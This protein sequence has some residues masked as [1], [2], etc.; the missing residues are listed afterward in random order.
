MAAEQD[1]TSSP[2][3]KAILSDEIIARLRCRPELPSSPPVRNLALNDTTTTSER[4]TEPPP[5]IADHTLLRL[6]GRG[7][8]GEVWLAVNV[9]GAYRAV[10]IVYQNRFEDSRPFDREFN[11]LLRYEPIS[12]SH[13][14]QVDILHVG[15][16]EVSGYFYYIMELADDQ[17]L[18][19]HLDPARYR[20]RTLRSDV[21]K[22]RRLPF[23]ECL[24]IGLALATAL[25]HLH[26][27]G[28]VHRD[29]KPSNIVFINGIPKLAD[30]GLIACAEETR[31]FVGTE[32]F[33]PPEGPGLPQADLYALG[34]VIYEMS[35]GRDRKEFPQL[36][37][38]LRESPDQGRLLELNEII[39]KACHPDPHQR[40]Q[41]AEEMHADLAMLQ[42]GKSVIGARNLERRLLLARRFGRVLIFVVLAALAGSYHILR[43]KQKIAQQLIRFQLAQGIQLMEEDRY[44]E[45]LPWF[46]ESLALG[47]KNAELHRLRLS[48]ILNQ[49]PRLI[50]LLPHR[51]L[52]NDIELSPD[53]QSIAT[54]SDDGSARVWNLISGTPRTPRLQHQMEVRSV[55]F[56][57]D[58]CHVITASSDG[59]ARVW[60]LSSGGN[61][62]PPLIHDQPV[63]EASFS[64]DGKLVLTACLD[65]SARIWDAVSGKLVG[66]PLSHALP[67]WRARF[68]PDGRHILTLARQTEAAQVEG[69]A[70][71]WHS[72]GDS[73][74]LVS[75]LQ[76]PKASDAVFSPDGQWVAT[77]GDDLCVRIWSTV[78]GRLQGTP[79]VHS[80]AVNYAEFSQNSRRLVAACE[81]KTARIWDVRSCQAL[82]PVLK[83]SAAVSQARFSPDDRWIV[84]ASEDRSVRLFDANTG[85][86]IISGL[87]HGGQITQ[88]SFNQD[89]L[90]LTTA[91]SDCLV[92][93]W[94]LSANRTGPLISDHAEPI[95]AAVLSPDGRFAVTAYGPL[96]G[97]SRLRVWNVLTG[98]PFREWQAHEALITALSLSP[99]GKC[100]VSA[101]ADHTARC[102]D[103]MRGEPLSEPLVHEGPVANA[104][105]SPDGRL[106]ATAAGYGGAAGVVRVWDAAT[107]KAVTSTLPHEGEIMSIQFG[108]NSQRLVVASG[109]LRGPSDARIWDIASQ[110][111]SSPRFKHAAPVLDACFSPDGLR[112]ATASQDQSAR[113][114]N[115]VTGS[116]ISPPIK[117]AGAVR[118]VIFNPTGQAIATASDDKTARLW[119]A[120]TGDPLTPVLPHLASVSL[121]RFSGDGRLLLTVSSDFQTRL[122]DPTTGEALAPAFH[123]Q[124]AI[125]QAVFSPDHQSVITASHD[126]TARIWPLTSDYRP[127]QDLQAMA[128]LLSGQ[129]MHASG[130]LVPLKPNALWATQKRL[131]SRYPKEFLLGPTELHDWH[132]RQADACEKNLDW[133]AA[134][135]HV[136]R[137]LRSQPQDSQ[138]L[139]RLDRLRQL[140]Q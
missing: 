102:W 80:G 132:L 107:G 12:R 8:Y 28:L 6:I 27:C 44:T 13:D 42:G 64:P 55:R 21:Q 94:K 65:G 70:C 25:G 40:Y 3:P 7:S 22:R 69:Q 82:G 96:K 60:D 136:E 47:P 138:L 76:H 140:T 57:P 129:T 84:T 127:V 2:M 91:S 23:D 56:S 9:T 103:P 16:N 68:S 109:V 130:G 133:N 119:D 100:L 81:D 35:M 123:H 15:R 77:R 115:A 19:Q 97:P 112:I 122:W 52:V 113:V 67:V 86:S 101:S 45:S 89:G 32:G 120:L 34:K 36:P 92:R 125:V 17:E 78:D 26:R 14:S 118:R 79:L 93:I 51:R 48:L 117:H 110:K 95:H 24:R 116:S 41:T 54:A 33:L 88:V 66:Q 53:G 137:S 90:L 5:Q 121:I 131:Q 18:G 73:Q 50:Q 20:P 39:T 105:F 62:A 99:D 31:S 61:P 74:F 11:G 75:L 108:P 49:C 29:V 128:C 134:R 10:K 59:T 1:Q 43:T 71:L 83:H 124:G 106:V 63:Q 104:L 111:L 37:A 30:V 46:A 85:E 38:D 87:T 139:K 72:F 4:K 98:H 58:G 135:F 114:W 126:H